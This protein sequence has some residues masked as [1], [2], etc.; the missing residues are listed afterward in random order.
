MKALI[1]EVQAQYEAYPYPERRPEDERKRLVVGSPSRVEEIDHYVFGGKR[2]WSKPFRA[3]VAGGGTGDGL[4]M[5][6][7]QLA[8]RGTP[9]EIVYLDLSGSSRRI[10]EE[11]ARVRGLA[12]ITFETGSVSCT[13]LLGNACQAGSAWSFWT[14][15]SCSAAVL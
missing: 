8:D 7:Q 10:A 2:D 12:S 4:I 9:A 11:R 5:L 15:P 14:N 1:N 13:I 3:L 6:A